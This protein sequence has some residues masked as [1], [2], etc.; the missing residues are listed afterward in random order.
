MIVVTGAAGFIGSNL[1]A[2]LNETGDDDV[3]A[4][5]TF[6]HQG[7]WMNLRKRV[8]RDFVPP[9]AIFDWLSAR[10]DIRAVVHLGANS[11]TTV[12]D[13][14]DVM[15]RN[16]R[17]SLRLL[18]WCTSKQVPLIYAS[19][20]ATYGDGEGGFD[21]DWSLDALRKLRPLNLYGW[22]KHVFDL[23]VAHRHKLGE[24]LPPACVGLKF[25]NVYG[26][27]EYHKGAMMSVVTKFFGAARR[28]DNIELFK[29]YRESV[30]DGAQ[31]RDFVYVRDTVNVI[32][33][34]LERRSDVG[35][36]NLGSGKARSFVDLIGAMFDALGVERRITFV[37]MPEQIRPGYQYFTEAK[38][39]R[40]KAAGYSVPIT[41]LENGVSDLVRTYLASADQYR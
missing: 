41:E 25:F 28:G 15:A 30:A 7:K 4:C 22:S 37:D 2:A 40:L 19:S 33:W 1:V 20:A 34:F 17:F 11:S 13:G 12:K 32:L 14:D 23:E 24:R 5:D 38:L 27:N 36:F 16:F 29:S 21:D 3:V 6:G 39:T 35:I 8:L 10:N 31:A 26:P 9:S 18:D